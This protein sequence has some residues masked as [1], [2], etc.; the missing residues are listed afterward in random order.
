VPINVL[1]YP[2]EG[3]PYSSPAYWTLALQTGGSMMAPSEDWP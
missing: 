2:L 1:L 3:D